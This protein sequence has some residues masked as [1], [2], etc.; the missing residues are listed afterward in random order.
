MTLETISPCS[1]ETLAEDVLHGADAIAEFLFGSPGGRRKVYYLAETSRLPVFRLG[2][3][4]CARRSVIMEWISRQE[5]RSC[6]Q[7]PP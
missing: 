2:S 4:L 7:S 3:A 5:H 6:T 1:S